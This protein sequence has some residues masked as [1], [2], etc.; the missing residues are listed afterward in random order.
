MEF[1]GFWVGE[2]G[3]RPTEETLQA[4]KD[5]PRQVDITGI[6]SWFGLVE[7]VAFSFSKTSLME[8]FRELLQPKMVFCWSD[9]LQKSFEAAKA[10]IVRLVVSGVKSFKLGEWLCVVTDWSR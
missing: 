6:R 10:E 2:D 8:P 7:Q 9:E 5:F 4:I 1:V 3:V